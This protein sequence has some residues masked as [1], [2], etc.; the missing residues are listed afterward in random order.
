MAI[1]LSSLRVTAEMDASGWSR[2][3][4]Q[5]NSANQSMAS[6]SDAT[7][8]AW[9]RQDA[10]A[11]KA[12]PGLSRLS[13]EYV[14]GYGEAAKFEAAVRRVGN[15]LDRAGGD[16]SALDRAGVLLDQIYR[17]YGMVADATTLTKQGYASLAPL[18]VELNQHYTTQT[19][20]LNRAAAAQAQYANASRAQADINSRLGV[21]DIAPGA[22]QQSADAFLAPYGG[23]A[24]VAEARAQQI[25]DRFT[26]ELNERMISGLAKSARESAAVFSTDLDQIDNIA[27]LKAEQIGANFQRSLNESF[28]IGSKSKS[29]QQSAQV[30]M[31]VDNEAKGLSALAEKYQPVLAADRMRKESLAEVQK[32][33]ASGIYSENQRL[34]AINRVNVAYQNAMQ[35]IKRQSEDAAK[36][37]RLVSGE[38]ANLSFQLNDV[39]TGIALGQ[40]PF[41]ILA[42]QGGQV[43]QIL[44][45][46]KVAVR[47]GLG[48]ALKDMGKTLVGLLTPINVTFG[49]IVA[50]AAA[51]LYAVNKYEAGQAELTRQLSGAGRGAGLNNAGVNAIAQNTSS[52]YGFSV[53]E[54]RQFAGTLASVGTIAGPEIEK[55]TKAGHD[56][57]KTLGIDS[58]EAAKLLASAFNDPISS[59]DQLN[60]K[61]GFADAALIRQIKNLQAQ[62]RLQEAQ[63][64]LSDAMLG[65]LA[66]SADVTSYWSRQWEALGNIVSNTADTLGRFQSRK[67]GIG[68]T[69]E[70]QAKMVELDR[71][72]LALF[73][74]SSDALDAKAKSLN[75]RIQ[76]AAKEAQNVKDR[77]ESIRIN[78]T[79]RSFLPELDDLQKLQ[80]ALATVTSAADNDAL[81]KRLG[82]TK[83]QV[84][85]AKSIATQLVQDFQTAFQRAQTQ[86]K[87]AFDAI[88]AF[89]PLQKAAIAYRQEVERLQ[90][91]T[92]LSPTEKGALAV[93]KYV[94]LLRQAYTVIQEQTRA[95]V[96]AGTQA[97]Q[98]A[99]QNIAL[100]GAS[101]EEQE[102]LR[103]ELQIN[104]Q[105]EQRISADHLQ[106]D[107]QALALLKQRGE[108]LKQQ[109][110]LRSEALQ[111]E[112]AL[113]FAEK[114]RF[115]IE[116]AQRP[117]SLQAAFSTAYSQY[118]N[119]PGNDNAKQAIIDQQLLAD[120]I[121]MTVNQELLFKQGIDQILGA[122]SRGDKTIFDKL[123][124]KPEV[125]AQAISG[126]NEIR[127]AYLTT[128]QSM[129]RSSAIALQAVTA[130]SPEQKARISQLQ[131]ELQLRSQVV[132]RTITQGEADRQAIQQANIV[133]QQALEQ[134]REAQRERELGARQGTELSK[135]EL[136]MV[137][138]SQVE[139]ERLRAIL[140]A[141]FQ[142]E[143]EAERNRIPM[144]QA[145]LD[146]LTQEIDKQAKLKQLTAE[147]NLLSDVAFER[148]Q[149]GRTDIE[150]DVASRLRSIYGSDYI[151]QMNGAI[152]AQITFNG[153][154]KQAKE[155]ATD[156]AMTF[157]STFRDAIRSG[158]SAFQALGQAGLAAL[159]RLADRL[160]DMAL[161]NLV[162]RAFGGLFGS[163]LFSFFGV[164]SSTP[165]VGIRPGG[166]E[167]VGLGVGTFTF[168]G[169]GY[170]GDVG[171]NQVAGLVHGQEFVVNARSTSQHLPLL[172]A[173]NDNR[174]PGYANGG[175][176]GSNVVPFRS[177]KVESNAAP[178]IEIYPVAGTTFDK[179]VD[180]DGTVRLIGRMIDQN[181]KTRDRALPDKIAAFQRDPRKRYG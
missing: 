105:I 78:Q 63:K 51:A 111:Q 138:K 122:I 5:I 49:A 94:E 31:D 13:R 134:L 67:S 113:R 40:S 156:V 180:N 44:A 36:G 28:S 84:Q 149:I 128:A 116:Q 124:L 147:R 179:E 54:S 163:S 6:S 91:A 110:V 157:G 53:Q 16:Q 1:A 76:N 102:R 69:P 114:A 172:Q 129:E 146:R 8:A 96:L 50:G 93:G 97:V 23:I 52:L 38:I 42:Q 175:Y 68:V 159:N 120:A 148:S 177:S 115:D 123:G 108:Q 15:A 106:N 74:T 154:L 87:I 64:L 150:Q 173:I 166:T 26:E 10:A 169:G 158:A 48:A 83:E 22:A 133:R 11:Q 19:E 12:I 17:K 71:K 107:P 33:A 37:G 136:E 82:L 65:S 46:S 75:D 131:T 57:A 165:S 88:T 92:D 170:T 56:F 60:S 43:Y 132:S 141:K 4:Q 152:A 41:M 155:I 167:G 130:Y 35:S 80:N 119:R 174:M 58:V 160:M 3:A 144:D 168:A 117:S 2:G 121:K 161:Q 178:K 98:T 62:N 90:T 142:L 126:L 39:L 27:R 79:V 61:L 86:A 29:A 127:N 139:Q 109:N 32:L 70:E 73:G 181:N 176:V 25:A 95:E 55:L 21:R 100:I 14:S 9:A 103:G 7:G 118:G 77:F 99:N 30:F 135:A 85:R 112:A 20:I 104:Q 125:I 72:I 162:S 140:Q 34:D 143:Q 164:G 59:V 18:V 151:N 66:R 145:K 24:G 89:S 171:R 101:I 153:Y 47:D 81:L 137:G 45:N